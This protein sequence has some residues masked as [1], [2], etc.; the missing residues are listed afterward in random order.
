MGGTVV[1][2]KSVAYHGEQLLDIY[3]SEDP[4]GSTPV[5]CGTAAERTSGTFSNRW[6]AGSPP[7]AYASS[8]PTGAARMTQT[9]AFISP[10]RSL[11][12]G[13]LLRPWARS[14]GWCWPA[15][16]SGRVRPWTWC[17][18]PSSSAV[19]VPAPLSPSRAASIDRRLLTMTLRM[20][21]ADRQER[22]RRSI[23]RSLCSSSTVP[24][25]KSCHRS[26]LWSRSHDFTKMGGAS[27][28]G[29]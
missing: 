21:G 19:G 29:R 3:E 27:R 4:E 10:R 18:T 23:P 2:R 7:R 8:F 14:I 6:P 11:S 9:D 1:C 20:S 26:D 24:R 17:V 12:S 15:G 5:S 13:T 28:S 16:L 25:M 22:P